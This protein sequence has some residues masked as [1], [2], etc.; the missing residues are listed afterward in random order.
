MIDI[1]ACTAA[2]AR[3][4]ARK[5]APELDP[6]A[7]CAASYPGTP[8]PEDLRSIRGV[9]ETRWAIVAGMV[10]TPARGSSTQEY[11]LGCAEARRAAL[12]AVD[13]DREAAR[14]FRDLFAVLGDVEIVAR[15]CGTSRG[16]RVRRLN[17]DEA[18]ALAQRIDGCVTVE[19][20]VDRAGQMLA[21]AG[22]LIT[23]ALARHI[24]AA[25]VPS[26]MVRDVRVCE[27]RGGVCARCFGLAPED[28]IWPA[29]G[30]DVGA[31]ASEAIAAVAR[32]L[33]RFTAHIC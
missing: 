15:D 26:V 6:L 27:A 9:I 18:G 13:R 32:R 3:G 8:Q 1:W 30:D 11:F 31:R 4:E 19:A 7:A 21:T 24:E 25:R 2:S 17:D 12:A 14:L 16:M 33:H 10:G 22:D 29:T 23:S 28:A 5:R 20:V